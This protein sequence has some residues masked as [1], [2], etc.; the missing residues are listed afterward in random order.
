MRF[1]PD[2]QD[3]DSP[4]TPPGCGGKLGSF[5]ANVTPGGGNTVVEVD[6]AKVDACEARLCNGQSSERMQI[7]I[8]YCWRIMIIHSL[9][10]I[11]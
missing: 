6:P 3:V 7:F 10:F 9:M 4:G 1:S 2:H 5:G 8:G 11:K